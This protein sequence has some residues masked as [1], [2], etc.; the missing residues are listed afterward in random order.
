VLQPLIVRK[1]GERYQL[2]AGERRWRAAQKAGLAE[3]PILVKDW[4]DSDAM[5]VGLVEN[6]QREDLNSIE[7]ALAYQALIEEHQ[8]THDRLSQEVGR[9]RTTVT[10][11]LRLL[12]LPIEI[13]KMLVEGRLSEGHARPLLAL[14]DKKGMIALAERTIREGLSVRQVEALVRERI[15]PKK[16]RDKIASVKKDPYVRQLEEGWT[17]ALG[18]KVAIVPRGPGGTLQISYYSNADLE[19]L[20]SKL[21]GK[22]N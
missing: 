22:G 9:D 13:Q 10:N 12:K 11:S 1:V 8:W 15:G 3:V 5:A 6:L 14:E 2:I 18:T 7:E 4:G 16:G 21:L 19:R 17:R 20:G